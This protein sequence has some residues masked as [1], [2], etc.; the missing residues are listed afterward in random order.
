MLEKIKPSFDPHRSVLGKILP[1]NTP[2]RLTFDTSEICNFKCTYCFRSEKPDKSWGYALNNEKMSM[3]I[4]Q[5]AV[6]QLLEFPEAPR[7]I[8]LSGN[9]EPLC[10][11]HIPEMVAFLKAKKLSS[12]L[13]IH[14]NAS[15]L[16]SDNIEKFAQCGI[17]K[18]VI[19]LQGLTDEAYQKTCGVKLDF[20]QF[21]QM[22]SALYQ[23]K[24][25]NTSI[26]IKIIDK[27]LYDTEDEK[28]FYSLFEQIADGVFIE[29]AVALWQ[30]QISY[31]MDSNSATNKFGR[32]LG[33][34]ECC[35][36]IFTNMTISP[37]G[38]IWPCCV[39]N[40]PFCLGNVRNT[41][42]LKAWNS[43]ERKELMC[44]NLLYG[45]DC[46]EQCKNCY[47]PKGYV[48]TEQDIID[49]YRQKILE[50]LR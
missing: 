8:A 9:G 19:S 10:N 49:P 3:D 2:F 45:H 27:A 39:I 12:K 26:N 15:L 23:H 32:D 35:P 7:V 34:I 25:K 6:E 43:M 18:I 36:I 30:D 28:R 46:H 40:P 50:R 47:F 24:S 44:Q 11:R 5:A 29:K 31:D 38:N 13:E 37:D 33:K 42:L 41:T 14:T 48:K 1:L 20:D 17:D 4:F 21:Y 22:L 16:T